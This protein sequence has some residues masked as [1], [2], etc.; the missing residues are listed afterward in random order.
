MNFMELESRGR[1]GFVLLESAEGE[2]VSLPSSAC[3]AY[4]HALAHG[5]ALLS[6]SL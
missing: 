5:L 6:T 1:L 3:G 2:S 4:L